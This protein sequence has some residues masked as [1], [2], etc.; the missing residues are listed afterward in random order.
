L[1]RI[2]TVTRAILLSLLALLFF[3]LM[4]LVIKHLSGQYNAAE[5]SFYRNVFGT[6]PSVIALW[7]SPAWHQAGRGLRVRQWALISSRGLIVAGAQLLFYLSLGRMAFATATTI[8]YSGALFMTG[9]AVLLLG[10]KVGTIRWLAVL[11]GFVGVVMIMGPRGEDFGLDAL[12]PVGAAA[13]YA[14]SG[15]TARMIDGD[16][17]SALANLYSS[18]FAVI[19]SLTLALIMGAFSPIQ[20]QSDMMWIV[21]MGGFGGTA[22][23]CMIVSYRMT[24]QSNL[25]PFSYFGI[26]LA[27]FLGWLV[28]DELPVQDLFPGAVLIAAGGLMVVWR[29][30]VQRR[31]ALKATAAAV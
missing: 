31:R 29:E 24:E 18:V 22:V 2:N 12:F 25:A 6:I 1:I 28:F 15:V 19:G 23:F 10:E 14:L 8:S 17:P 30:R 20:S 11:I 16:V 4:G 13:L 9:F 5:L 7:S 26:P 21:A 3:D 27:F